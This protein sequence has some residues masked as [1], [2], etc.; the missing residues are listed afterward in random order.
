M[1]SYSNSKIQLQVTKGIKLDLQ[2]F[3]INRIQDAGVNELLFTAARD[4]YQQQD[5]GKISYQ[6]C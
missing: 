1:H 2:L 5:F 6:T 3:M 4:K